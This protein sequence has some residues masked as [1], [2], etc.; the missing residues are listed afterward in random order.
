MFQ[1]SYGSERGFR[2]LFSTMKML[3]LILLI[4]PVLVDRYCTKQSIYGRHGHLSL[5]TDLLTFA[6]ES[7]DASR[8]SCDMTWYIVARKGDLT[9]E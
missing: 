1:L 8:I 6:I 2:E 3:A 9:R 7:L 5:T 4:R